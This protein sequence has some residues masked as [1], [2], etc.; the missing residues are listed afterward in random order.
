MARLDG[1]LLA[2][3]LGVDARG[4]IT[5]IGLNQNVVVT[6]SLP[7]QN[8]RAVIAHIDAGELAADDEVTVLFAMLDPG[9][10]VMTSFEVQAKLG[11]QVPW[12][13]VRPTLD[14]PA[15][16][17]FVPVAYGT[18]AIRV[19]ARFSDGTEQSEQVELYVVKPAV[20]SA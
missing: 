14:V 4:A 9:D 2:E 1:L 17:L 11:G 6:P 15:E 3:G 8:R 13:E 16:V 20:E 5:L 7:T 12:P 19:T 18:H 10:Q